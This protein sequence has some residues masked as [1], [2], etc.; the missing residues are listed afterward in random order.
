MLCYIDLIFNADKETLPCLYTVDYC[1][2]VIR[3]EDMTLAV[4]D[5]R[6]AESLPFAYCHHVP[7]EGHKIDHF[8][9]S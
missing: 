8:D 5:N 3:F 4:D 1:I 9:C 2:G 7:S 6:V